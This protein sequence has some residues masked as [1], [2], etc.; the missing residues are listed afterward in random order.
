[1]NKEKVITFLKDHPVVLPY[2]VT[3][4]EADIVSTAKKFLIDN[5]EAKWDR[6]EE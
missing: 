3:E 1:M 6:L 2:D 5:L 4:R